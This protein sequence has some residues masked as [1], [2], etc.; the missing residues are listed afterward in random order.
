MCVLDAAPVRGQSNYA[1]PY[2]ITTLAGTPI[3]RGYTNGTDAMALFYNPSGVCVD[4]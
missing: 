2:I 4:S 1:N 3:V